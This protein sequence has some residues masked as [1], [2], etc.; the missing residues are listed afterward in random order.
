MDGVPHVSNVEHYA[1]I[2]KEKSLLRGLIHATHAIQQQALEAEDDAD[3]ILDRAESSI[4][5][6][7]KIA[8]A[9]GLVGVRKTWSG[10]H[11]AHL[12]STEGRRIT[13]FATG[14]PA[15]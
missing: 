11:R 13:G 10:K 14:Y 4:F 2:V 5:Q 15:R 9:S 3:A 1:R 7:A 6:L 8:C 12:A